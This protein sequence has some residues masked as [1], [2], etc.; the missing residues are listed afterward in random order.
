MSDE[1]GPEILRPTHDDMERLAAIGTPLG[2][3]FRPSDAY[4]LSFP[5]LSSGER[6]VFDYDYDSDKTGQVELSFAVVDTLEQMHQWRNA[7]KYNIVGAIGWRVVTEP[8]VPET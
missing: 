8:E 5:D 4:P 2:R 7:V 6:L 3:Y 1:Q